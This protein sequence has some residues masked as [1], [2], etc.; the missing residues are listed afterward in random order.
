MYITSSQEYGKVK[1]S[2]WDMPE[3][4]FPRSNIFTNSFVGGQIIPDTKL[5]TAKTPS[6]VHGEFDA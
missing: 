4:Y 5:N 3:K 1:P 2:Q 6:R